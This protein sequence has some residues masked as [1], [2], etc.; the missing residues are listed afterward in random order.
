[1]REDEE[2]DAL[3]LANLSMYDFESGVW[4]P[5]YTSG[6]APCPRSG[7]SSTSVGDDKLVVF[8]GMDEEGKFLNDVSVLDTK[9]FN[10]SK[11]KTKGAPLKPRGYRGPS[12]FPFP[13]HCCWHLF[14]TGLLQP[15]RVWSYMFFFYNPRNCLPICQPMYLR[16]DKLYQGLRR[17]V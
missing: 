11:P 14:T 12:V 6:E 8:G 15:G 7:H 13:L 3:L 17:P 16:V 2:D 1:M 10:W 9:L 5:A 4:F